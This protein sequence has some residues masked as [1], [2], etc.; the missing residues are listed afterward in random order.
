MFTEPAGTSGSGSPST[1]LLPTR[2]FW[3]HGGR[4]VFLCGSFTSWQEMIPMSPVEGCPSVFQVICSLTPG[5]YQYKFFVDSEWHYD[6]QQPF[7]TDSGG[8]YNN[9]VVV[10]E[11]D[12]A[13]GSQGIEGSALGASMDVDRDLFPDRVSSN[14]FPQNHELPVEGMQNSTVADADASRQRINDFLTSH[15]VYEIL[16]DSGKVVALDISLP[17]K[18]AFHVLYEQGIPV[19]PL[20]DSDRQQFVG[21]LTAADFIEILRQIG[22]HPAL[23]SEEEL[24]TH[25]IAAWKYEKMVISRLAETSLSAAQKSLHY[26]GPDDSLKEVAQKLLRYQVGAVPVLH[27][28]SNEHTSPQLL[29]LAT[30][31]GILKCLL[32]HL[33]HATG[34]IPLLNQPLDSLRVGTWQKGDAPDRHLAV[35][36]VNAPL[37]AALALLIQ[38][39]VSAIPIVDDNGCLYDIYARSDIT[40]LARDNTYAHVQ[41]DQLTI[42]Q[43]LQLVHDGSASTGVAPV[44]RC[45]MCLRTDTLKVILERLSKPGVRRLICVEAGSRR[46]EGIVTLTD[47]FNFLLL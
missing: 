11:P 14:G 12:A 2:F 38:A 19:A 21:M 4:R 15:T 31:S 17:I 9:F 47:I 36:K 5:Y 1:S 45:P 28:S 41:L 35:L 39:R 16:P 42:G 44:L 29:H 13:S 24:E 30:L 27:F 37:S 40:A 32:R 25:T 7:V 3:T 20:W 18:Q 23:L 26:V 33:Q 46:I 10:R 8:N 43:A 22:S 34:S 6:E